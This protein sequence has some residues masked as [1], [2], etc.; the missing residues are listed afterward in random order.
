MVGEGP[1]PQHMAT[2]VIHF[3]S[4]LLETVKVLCVSQGLK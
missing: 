4:R 2:T 1:L 3:H